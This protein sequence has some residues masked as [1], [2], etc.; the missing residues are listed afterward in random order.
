MT[1]SLA[2]GILAGGR[3]TR[4][5]GRD[6]GWIEVDGVA[7]IWRVLNALS[8]AVDRV[9]INANRHLDEYRGLGV[10]VVP[11]R[12]P[13]HPGPFAGLATLFAE[14]R[15]DA[16]L[17]VPVD[18][19]RIPDDFV[20]RM[21]AHRGPERFHVVVA[22]DE[23]GMQPLFALYPAAL[24]ANAVENFEVGKRSVREWQ[25]RFPTYVCRFPG[26]RFGNL[27]SIEDLGT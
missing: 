3:G 25:H 9:L 16:L 5:G 15:E 18:A 14:L 20:A 7:Q 26:L 19:R 4:F 17:T 12:W 8:G 10:E 6:K 11:D 13:D 2:L 22:E 24:A 21:R 23:D 27:N 1:A